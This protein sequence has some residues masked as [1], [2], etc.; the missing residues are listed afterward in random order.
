MRASKSKSSSRQ[1]RR[2]LEAHTPA[3]DEWIPTTEYHLTATKQQVQRAG[4]GPGE[5]QAPDTQTW[6]CGLS[7]K[8]P[9]RFIWQNTGSP[10]RSQA[11]K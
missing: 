5:E 2:E 7:V 3:A 4:K 9:Y 8:C 11:S 10:A 6:C 1:F